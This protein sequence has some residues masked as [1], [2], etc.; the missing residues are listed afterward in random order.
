M[1]LPLLSMN[2]QDIKINFK[3]KNFSQ[4]INYDGDE[5]EQ[6][7]VIDSKIMAEYIFLDDIILEKFTTQKH[8]YI[9]EQTQYTGDELIPINTSIYNSSLK[10]NNS[11]KE[12]VFACVKKSSVDSNNHFVYSDP[13]TDSSL[14]NEIAF[15]IEGKK[16]LEYLP[17]VYFRTIFPNNVHSNIPLKYVYCL[18]FSIMPEN[19]QPSGSINMSRFNDI[20]ISLKLPTNN[21]DIYFY[22]FAIS[23]NIVTIENG[24][25]SLEF[26]V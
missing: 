4:L 15:L 13:T 21:E 14:I 23:Y 12:L 10:F 7:S 1:A 5:P 11:V 25:L 3:L 18:P 17:E 2:Y 6:V 24:F 19:Q 9:I 16:K 22:I 20:T 8:S 26:A